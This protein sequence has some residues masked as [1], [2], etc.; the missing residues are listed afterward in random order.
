MT[1]GGCRAEGVWMRLFCVLTGLALV[2]LIPFLVWGEDFL[3]RF[4]SEGAR[5]WLADR[6]L[7]WGWLMGLFL[8]MADLVLP[9]PATSVISALGFVYGAVGGGLIGAAGSFL[10]GVGAYELCRRGGGR[11]A[12]R[13]LGERDR[14]RAARIFAGTMGGWLVALSRWMPLL[15][16]MVA[17]MAGLTGMPRRRFY[18]ALGC[19]CV[20]M[21]LMFAMIGAAGLERPGLALLLSAVVPGGLYGLA[22]WGLK[23]WSG[24]EV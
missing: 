7:A 18:V 4:G 3:T 6:G 22:V 8:L 20:P 1:A 12:D 16:E 5:M 9:V 23:S 11:A 24:G 13:L 17:C 2:V 14:K 21:G 19:G 15:P 10:S